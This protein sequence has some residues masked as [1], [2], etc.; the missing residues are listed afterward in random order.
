MVAITA[1]NGALPTSLLTSIGSGF[2]LRHDAAASYLR[3]LADGCP[4]GITTAYRTGAEQQHLL[5]L[6][7]YPHAEYPG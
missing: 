5:N 3:A 1:L 7:G 4:T 6:Y 2:T